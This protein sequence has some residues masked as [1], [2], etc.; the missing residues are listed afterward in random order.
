[1]LIRNAHAC[2]KYFCITTDPVCLAT[3]EETRRGNKFGNEFTSI[4]MHDMNSVIKHVIFFRDD[5]I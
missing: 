4:A 3:E 2:L 5:S 1:M